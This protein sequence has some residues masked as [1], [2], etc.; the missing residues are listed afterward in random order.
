M[1]PIDISSFFGKGRKTLTVIVFL[2]WP[3]WNEANVQIEKWDRE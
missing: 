2:G 3:N 1:L